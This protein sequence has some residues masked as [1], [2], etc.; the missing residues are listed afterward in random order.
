MNNIYCDKASKFIETL[1]PDN[2]L[3]R[4]SNRNRWIFRGQ[5]DSSWSMVP[6]ALR[7]GMQLDY[8]DDRVLGPLN[9][10]R[11]QIEFE[12]RLLLNF[13]TLADEIGLLIPGD[14]QEFRKPRNFI[15]L[16]NTYANNWPPLSLLEWMAIAQHHGVPTRLL[17]FTYSPLVAAYF[18]AYE[19]IALDE[20]DMISRQNTNIAVWAVDLYFLNTMW[21]HEYIDI[22]KAPGCIRPV[23]VSRSNNPFLHQ[24]SALF[25]YDE[26][27]MIKFKSYGYHISVDAVICEAEQ[28]VENDPRY[29]NYLPAMYKIETPYSEANQ[30]MYLLHKHRIT[31]A[32]LMP[33]YD[34]V[35]K[36]LEELRTVFSR[37]HG[38]L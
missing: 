9:T 12:L 27:E 22:H 19:T 18:A 16:V 28:L 17:D 13:R 3:W 10:V 14:T 11:E 30:V 32:H 33:T 25:L 23:T 24:Q 6:K 38:M 8:Y 26:K 37:R 20:K 15:D 29:K 34:N 1:R 35:T 31:R 4:G 36:T 2:E 21:D 7:K 5:S